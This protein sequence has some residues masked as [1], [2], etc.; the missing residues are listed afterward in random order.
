[1]IRRLLKDV[2]GGGL[3]KQ[4]AAAEAGIMLDDI[5]LYDEEDNDLIA[6]RRAA[7][8]RRR[9]LLR[10]KGGD[11]LENLSKYFSFCL[12]NIYEYLTT[13]FLVSNPKTSAFAK[14]AQAIPG[15]EVTVFLSDSE[16]EAEEPENTE[17]VHTKLVIQEEDDEEEDE[18]ND[19]MDIYSEEEE[20]LVVV[21]S[22]TNKKKR[23]V[24]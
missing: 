17:V 5:D 20:D 11:I 6:V 8:A 4:K 18:D 10:R 22:F 9:K 3:R 16:A 21:K 7:E 13:F 15:E 12:R 14:A 1:M 19:L 23:E 2:T 24:V